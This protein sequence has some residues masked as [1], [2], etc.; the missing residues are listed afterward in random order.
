MLL[1]RLHLPLETVFYVNILAIKRVFDNAKHR[2]C[3]LFRFDTSMLKV[4]A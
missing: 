2:W 1:V 4:A 3:A